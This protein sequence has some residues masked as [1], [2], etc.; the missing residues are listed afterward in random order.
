MSCEASTSN[1]NDDVPA[2][3]GTEESSA[4][5]DLKDLVEFGCIKNI[6]SHKILLWWRLNGKIKL[7]ILVASQRHLK[8]RF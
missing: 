1:I 5:T 3:V 2:E 4:T 8:I 6:S 7:G